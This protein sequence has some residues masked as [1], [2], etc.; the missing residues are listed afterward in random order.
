[1]QNPRKSHTH[2]PPPRATNP[3]IP[4]LHGL[5]ALGDERWDEAIVALR[6]YVELAARPED[7]RMAFRNLSACYLA[8]ERYDEALAELDE[9]ARGVADDP[10]IVQ[11]RGVIYACAARL[12]EAIA[13]FESLARRWPEQARRLDIRKVLREL[14]RAEQGEISAGSYLVNHLQEQ[15]EHN[16]ELD[17]FGLVERKARRMIVA[18][19]DRSEGHFALGVACLEQKRYPEALE[20]F[21]AAHACNPNH[22]PTLYNLGHTYVQ[23]DEPAQAIP[24]LERALRQDPRQLAALHQLGVACERLGRRAEAVAW[25]R[26]ALKINASYEMA[27]WRLH[28]VGQGPKPTEPPLSPQGQQARLLGPV[29]KARMRRPEVYRNGGV[30]LTYSGE[31]GFVLEDTENLRNATIHAG[32]PFIVARIPDEDLLD[33][34]GMV[35]LLLRMANAENTRDIAVLTYYT[36]RPIFSYQLRFEHGKQVE[37]SADGRF[38]VTEAPR[39]FKLRIDSDLSTIY[40]D[41]MQGMLICLSQRP[42]P[43]IMVSTLG[44]AAQKP[45]GMPGRPRRSRS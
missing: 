21:Q 40:G 4:W 28:E 31:V 36:D 2:V 17:D 14:R 18:D 41:P 37:F 23:M 30:T 26:R 10:D 6:R 29:V 9:A 45:E 39:F 33:L 3:A 7:R 1:M 32:G 38:V 13:A 16:M 27:Q 15:I 12:P 25:W 42:Q 20:A 5:A 44:L 11:S 43:G 8:L 24:W 34:I 19:P 35:K 22:A